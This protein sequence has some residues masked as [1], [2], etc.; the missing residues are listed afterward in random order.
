MANSLNLISE[1]EIENSIFDSFITVHG[2]GFNNA[3]IAV[4]SKRVFREENDSYEMVISGSPDQWKAQIEH[5]SDAAFRAALNQLR[6]LSLKGLKEG[7]Y[8]HSAS[9][10]L[11]GVIEGFYGKPWSHQQRKKGITYFAD[12]N[13][14]HFMLAPKDDPWQRFDWRV[15]FKDQFLDQIAELNA[16]SIANGIQMSVSLSPGL[17]IVYSDPND[18][19]A[20]LVRYKQLYAVGIRH[21][22]L[23]VDDIPWELQHP[24]DIKKFGNIADAHAYYANTLHSELQKMAEDSRLTVCPLVYRGRGSE[25]YIVALGNALHS[26]IDLMWT[27]RQICSEYL[28]TVDAIAFKDFT[29]KKPF[30]WDNYPV[31]DA[32]MTE[33][34]HVGPITGRQPDL[35]SHSVGLLANPMD[36][37]ELSLIAIGTIGDYLWDAES[38]D[39]EK[40]WHSTMATL[41]P[42]D[43][44]REVISRVFRC[45]FGSCLAQAQAPEFSKML[46]DAKYAW[47]TK[48]L[49]DGIKILIDAA[50]QMK[51]DTDRILG[52]AFSMPEWRVEALPWIQKYSDGEVA[53]RGI[54]DVLKVS[55][56]T[57]DGRLKAPAGSR[58]KLWKIWSSLS[59]NQTRLFGGS[60]I[61]FI[62]ELAAEI[63]DGE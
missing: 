38:Y 34:L 50:D 36:R 55:T 7:K 53:L 18:A 28:D 51:S 19:E 11:R 57:Q 13:M 25:P 3:S 44:D 45:S 49:D 12:L 8:S 58:D 48:K 10:A 27:G 2:S 24:D 4:S 14:N 17:T 33:E 40:S 21:F 63:A 47:R 59:K 42:N 20:I 16:H 61:L 60:F 56:P 41:V 5:N 46:D 54:I 52:T 35:G 32:E 15:P 39:S 37:F 31:N 62:G 30:Y 26:D 6:K 23:L 1:S 9:F 29:S 22:G 43:E